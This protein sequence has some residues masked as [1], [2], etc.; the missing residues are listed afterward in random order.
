MHMIQYL[1]GNVCALWVYR[2]ICYVSA[3]SGYIWSVLCDM[4]YCMWYVHI[5]CVLL[6]HILSMYVFLCMYCV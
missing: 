4:S 5:P 3:L 1:S 6:Q 2:Y